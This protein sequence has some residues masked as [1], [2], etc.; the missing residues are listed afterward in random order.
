M[1]SPP[2]PTS[3]AVDPWVS[4]PEIAGAEG[5]VASIVT[6]IGEDVTVLVLLVLD[7]A[8]KVNVPSLKLCGT[9][10]KVPA[11]DVSV[12]RPSDTPSLK[13]STTAPVTATINRTGDVLLV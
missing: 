5:G 12:A 10:V 6:T 11:V 4:A 3:V 7:V 8:V 2:V 1:V 13:T 9:N